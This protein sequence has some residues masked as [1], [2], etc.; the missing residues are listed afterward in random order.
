MRNPEHIL[1][2]AIVKYLWFNKIFNFAVP[3][4]G[5]RDKLT[6]IK[7]KREGVIAGAPDLII[8]LPGKVVFVE[9]KNG[10]I[11]RQSQK[12]KWFEKEIKGFGFDYVVWRDFSDAVKFVM[13]T[14]RA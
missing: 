3:N 13:E 7:L 1:Q 8:V 2:S 9:L 6:A 12:Q 14:K 10:K 4:G 11:G 5:R